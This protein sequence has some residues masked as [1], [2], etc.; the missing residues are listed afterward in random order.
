MSTV[1]EREVLLSTVLSD[2][3]RTM[4]TDFPIQRILDHLIE[5]IVE[6]LPISSAG[7]TLLSPTSGPRRVA[8]SNA[9]ALRFEELQT[10]TGQGPCVA[11]YDT[12]EAVLIS[13]LRSG[14]ERFPSFCAE[15]HQAGLAAVAGADRDLR[16]LPFDIVKIDHS[17][18]LRALSW[19]SH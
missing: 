4:V 17:L 18:R 10:E 13:D 12:G 16:R 19:G 9:D 11:A 8:A 6:V 15:A 14:D 7:V 5:R 1:D 3:A 2:F